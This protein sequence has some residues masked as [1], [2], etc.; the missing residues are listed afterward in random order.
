MDDEVGDDGVHL[1]F[2]GIQVDGRFVRSINRATLRASQTAS[3]SPI[4]RDN[5]SFGDGKSVAGYFARI[6]GA[7]AAPN[8]AS[9][10][11]S[12]CSVVRPAGKLLSA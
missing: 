1:A 8:S 5:A 11:V 12:Y 4:R 2:E 10:V 6:A 9:T 3:T 7:S